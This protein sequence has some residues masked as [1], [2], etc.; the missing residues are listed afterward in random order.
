M[1]SSGSIPSAATGSVALL[2]STRTEASLLR[3]NRTRCTW[4]LSAPIQNFLAKLAPDQ[5][6]EGKRLVLQTATQ[7]GRGDRIMFSIAPRMVAARK[8]I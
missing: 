3:G 5:V 2:I 7:H 6:Q 1:R 8:P 4:K